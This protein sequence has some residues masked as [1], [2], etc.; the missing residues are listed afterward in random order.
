MQ[1]AL[2]IECIQNIYIHIIYKIDIFREM[3][4][5]DVLTYLMYIYVCRYIHMY[6][7]SGTQSV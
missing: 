1:Y 6:V 2:P 4:V 3:D 5:K 7:K